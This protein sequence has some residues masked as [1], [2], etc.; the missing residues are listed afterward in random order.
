M[1]KERQPSPMR[2]VPMCG[3]LGLLLLCAAEWTGY[4]ALL[5]F[6]PLALTML[7]LCEER[8]YG[9]AILCDLLI[10]AIVLFLPVPHYAWLAFVCVLAPYV[11]LRHAIQDLKNPR[12][13]TL[14][15]V[16][17][18]VLWTAL[19]VFGL[20]FLGVELVTMFSPLITA[21]IGLGV[22]LFLFLLD[23]AYQL[24]LKAYRKRV[25]RFL[26]PRA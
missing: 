3:L 16:V 14:L 20:H 1:R 15:P 4:F 12:S 13:A 6:L 19:V 24:A 2:L 26:L 21:L 25:R 11:P 8:L 18:T 22:L 17:I 5:F 23:A 7:P 10:A 9:Y